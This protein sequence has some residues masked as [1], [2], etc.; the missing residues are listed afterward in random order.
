MLSV[1]KARIPGRES[2]SDSQCENGLASP[3]GPN[4]AGDVVVASGLGRRFGRRWAL[5]DVDLRLARG[6]ALMVVG[7]NGS[8]K[9]TLLRL[10]STAL[11][12][13]RGSLRIDG[14]DSRLQT[15]ELRKRV[16]FLGHHSNTYEAMTALQNIAVC[17]RLLGQTPDR[18][19]ILALL[20]RVGL[21]RR[22]DD[23]I[24]TFSSGMRKRIAFARLLLQLDG[25]PGTTPGTRAS[26]VMLDEPYGQLDSQGACFVDDLIRS[27]KDRGLT[28][29]VATHLLNRGGSICDD[30]ILLDHGRVRWAG[31]AGS[32]PD[33][34]G[35]GRLPDL[36]R[37]A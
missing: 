21:A 25:L 8:G 31:P 15:A 33:E 30:A 23:S 7:H 9:S 37:G 2:F 28:I 22:A 19:A 4:D 16:A 29:L 34:A 1:E 35:P 5:V 14:L 27:L 32:V 11:R 13:D 10:L 26:V 36:S 6:R 24:S 17:A 3:A 18:Q 12:A 20:G